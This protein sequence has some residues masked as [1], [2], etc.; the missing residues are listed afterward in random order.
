MDSPMTASEFWW[1]HLSRQQRQ[2]IVNFYKPALELALE[3]KQPFD[4]VEKAYLV[5]GTFHNMHDWPQSK[6]RTI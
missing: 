4:V 5:S 2:F 6:M 3:T 1:N